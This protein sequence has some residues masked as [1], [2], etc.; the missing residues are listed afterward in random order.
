MGHRPMYARKL[1]IATFVC[2]A[3][4]AHADVCQALYDAIKREAMYCGFQCE[5]QAIAP[6]QQAY[7]E[8]CIVVRVPFELFS[9]FENLPEEPQ[10]AVTALPISAQ[11]DTPTFEP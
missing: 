11:V 6:L 1:L 8:R 5:Q 3:T 4:P 2:C 7:E 9:A 10:R